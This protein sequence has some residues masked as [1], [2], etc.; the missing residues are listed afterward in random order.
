MKY[1]GIDYGTKR[2]GLAISDEE[3]KLAFPYSVIINNQNA[4]NTI[5]D[6]VKDNNIK[7]I[8]IGESL[9]YSGKAN[10]IMQEIEKF[11]EGLTSEI[12]IPVH[13]EKEW[14]SSIESRAFDRGKDNI[15][16]PRRTKTKIKRTD[17]SAAAIILQR[18]LDK[19]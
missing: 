14:M 12:Q 2:I 13:Y 16:N 15:E 1:L 7:N 10:I 3:G 11:R 4:L 19:Q 5:A 17:D 6:I 18:F 9:N 8:V